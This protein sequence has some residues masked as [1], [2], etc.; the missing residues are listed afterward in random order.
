MSSGAVQL[1]VYEI[2]RVINSPIGISKSQKEKYFAQFREA[3]K[4][5]N[6]DPFDPRLKPV[7]EDMLEELNTNIE[8]ETKYVQREIN[9]DKDLKKKFSMFHMFT[10]PFSGAARTNV[11]KQEST[12]VHL[13]EELTNS[14]DLLRDLISLVDAERVAKLQR[15]NTATAATAAAA[16]DAPT[17]YSR[18]DKS[19]TDPLQNMPGGKRRRNKRTKRRKASR[20]AT[21]RHH[22]RR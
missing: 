6:F 17:Q 18:L 11:K 22:K 5:A 14:R 2:L 12:A 1:N 8:E 16:D 10:G 9:E 4:T 3:L 19:P 20:K 7:M 13:N 15:Q 21:R